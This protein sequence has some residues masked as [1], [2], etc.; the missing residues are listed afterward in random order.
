M[1]TFDQSKPTPL[2]HGSWKYIDKRSLDECRADDWKILNTQKREYLA[3]RQADEILRMLKIQ[4]TDP[5]FGYTVNIYQHCLQTATRMLR[6]NLPEE[7]IVVGLMHDIGYM[8]CPSAHG[9]F[10]ALLLRPYISE[11]NLWMLQRH[12][13][14]QQLHFH[15]SDGFDPNEREQWRGQPY[16]D[17]AAKFVAEYDQN[18]INLDEE[19]LPIEEFEPMVR[20]LIGR[21]AQSTDTAKSEK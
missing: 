11:K 14:F 17:W 8:V 18:T 7:D 1:T 9:E 21:R 15:E 19:I 4:A 2:L 5:S 6:D 16:F 20:R 3:E 10:A 13:I 12:E